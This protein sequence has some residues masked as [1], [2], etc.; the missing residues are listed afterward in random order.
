[1]RQGQAGFS[2]IEVLL[3]A[4]LFAFVAFGAF[5]VVRQMAFSAAHL[6][7]RQNAYTSMERL[8]AQL[9][10][11]A[12]GALALTATAAGSGAND[13]D[14][15]AFAA[16]DSSGPHF[17]A[18]RRFP[19][20]AV[21]DAVPPDAL[22]RVA[23]TRP[24]TVC[25]P[26][27]AAATV[28]SG[29]T[30]FTA[31]STNADQLRVHRDPY[32]GNADTTFV[33]AA[34]SGSVATGLT[35]ASGASIAGGNAVVEVTVASADA[36]RAVDL[37]AGVFPTGFTD[38]LAYTCD[39]RCTVGHA[40]DGAALTITTCALVGWTQPA[41]SIGGY[42]AVADPSGGGAEDLVPNAWWISGVFVF[43]YSGT[44]TDGSANVL[45][46]T[47]FVTNAGQAVP[48]GLHGTAAPFGAHAAI[49]GD[50]NG[51]AA[52]AQAWLAEF[53]PYIADTGTYASSTALMTEEQ[54]CAGVAADG[55]AGN[56]SYD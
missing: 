9:R 2:L 12:R 48:D 1:M 34:V 36:A 17:W 45:D 10:A 51:D 42:G 43:R 8:A 44:A 56:Y 24:L 38:V 32:V 18:Y 20:H 49:T 53:A 39:A 30:A 26:T 29:V 16:A 23:G 33:K 27:A 6:G 47:I 5:E 40:A 11:E 46:H 4:A 52:A 14:E 13:C 3:A 50:A 28:L 31:T 19:H 54:H 55:T 22:L 37:V 7:A 35:D 41:S 15:L 25:D 21:G